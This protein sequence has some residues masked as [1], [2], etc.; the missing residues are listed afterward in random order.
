MIIGHNQVNMDPVKVQEVL[1]WP[2]PE[3]VKQVRGFLDFGNF[4]RQFINHYSDIA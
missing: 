1:D 4:Y 2:I 3:T